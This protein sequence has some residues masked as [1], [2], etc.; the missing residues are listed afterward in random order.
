M[1]QEHGLSLCA[2]TEPTRLVTDPLRVQQVLANLLSNAI[3]YTPRDGSIRVRI[4]RDEQGAR[5]DAR[6]GVEVRD[7]GPGIPADLRARVFDEFF[8]VRASGVSTNGNG[9]GLAISR[10]IARLLGGDVVYADNDGGGSIFTLWLRQRT[11]AG[12]ARH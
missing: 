9:L 7:T 12:V 10:R 6:V 5:Q 3:K 8:R 4:I 1:A 2:K 11:E